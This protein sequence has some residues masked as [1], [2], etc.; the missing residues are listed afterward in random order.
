MNTSID[1]LGSLVRDD[2]V[3]V[4]LAVAGHPKTPLFGLKILA[5]DPNVPIQVT[6]A[7]NPQAGKNLLM[8]LARFDRDLE[9]Q[10]VARRR[11]EPLLRGE[12]REDVLERWNTY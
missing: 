10:Q 3:E 7:K 12:I 2:E 11:L 1:V 9:V 4:R 6:V 5:V 8:T